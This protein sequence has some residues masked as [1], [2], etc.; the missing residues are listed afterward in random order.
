MTIIVD[1]T[2]LHKQ[3]SQL[4]KSCQWVKRHQTQ[5]SSDVKI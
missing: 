2:T 1:Q 5:R 4:V 3:D